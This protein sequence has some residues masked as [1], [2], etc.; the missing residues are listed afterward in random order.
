VLPARSAEPPAVVADGSPGACSQAPGSPAIH[1]IELAKRYRETVALA[2]LS[3]TVARGEVFGFLGP[4]G[5]GKTTA[6]RLL[7]GLARPT[8]GEAMVLGAPAGNME[9]RR[10]IGYLPELFRFQSW[11]TAREVLVLHC[12]LLQLPRSRW[13]GAATEALHIVGLSD[14]AGDKVGTFS[15]GMQQRLGLAVALLGEPALV[16]LDEPTSALDPV[17]RHD[18]RQV[19]R[20]LRA[21]G[22]TVFLNTHLLE[23]AE[24]VCDR[25]TVISKGKTLAAGTLAE[26]RRGRPS[27]RLQV[28]GLRDGWRQQLGW[29]GRW[30]AEPGDWLLVEDVPDGQVP[31]LVDALVKLGGRVEAV[32]PQRRSLEDRFLELLGEA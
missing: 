18:V 32:I 15:K 4:N 25:V 29:Y 14:R 8:G 30:T 26:L 20:Q 24:Q 19:I 16:L 17:G 11:L 1:T 2:G 12:R 13:A 27:V 31:D 5:S 10:Q 21:R 22:A 9:T 6:V 28:T 23:E 7:L 3:M